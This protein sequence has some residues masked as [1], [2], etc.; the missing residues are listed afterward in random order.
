MNRTTLFLTGLAALLA[1]G[2]G[3]LL[4]LM[5]AVWPLTAANQRGAALSAE[6][7]LTSVAELAVL[8]FYGLALGLALLWHVSRDW[9]G[10]RSAPFRVAPLAVLGALLAFP[11]VIGAGL[12]VLNWPLTPEGY[13]FPVLQLLTVLLPALVALGLIER[14]GRRR[15]A[16]AL[17]IVSGGL[18]GRDSRGNDGG[19]ALTQAVI[20]PPSWR[21]VIGAL[22]WGLSGGAAIAMILEVVAVLVAAVAGLLIF[23]L[24]GYGEQV[25]EW[26]DSMQN[27]GA[28]A[29]DDATLR[30]VAGN[31][32]V[33]LGAILAVGVVVPLIEETAKS[34]AVVILRRRL[35]GPRD[36]F[37]YGAAA[38]VGFGLLENAI[39]NV[40]DL[41]TWWATASLRFGTL[42]V[43]ALGTGLIGVGWYYALRRRNWR[44]LGALALAAFSVHGLWNGSQVVIIALS[45]QRG[46]VSDPLLLAQAG[47]VAGW[48]MLGW[49]VLLSLVAAS[50]LIVLPYRLARVGEGGSPRPAAP[51]YRVITPPPLSAVDR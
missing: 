20:G 7:Q 17:A 21:R 37:L 41:S 51:V 16:P 25:R 31:P 32:W 49:T 24:L 44:R 43:H 47:D 34:L 10:A 18:P 29:L 35:T 9:R 38:G 33:I 48:V 11:L 30:E 4:L 42:L 28:G 45:V 36:A 26:F 12:T 1:A 46:G 5:Y 39:Y 6:E 2:M 3:G 14:A 50:L 13:V 19:A 8:G 22:G 15:P 27:G 23:Q 40:G